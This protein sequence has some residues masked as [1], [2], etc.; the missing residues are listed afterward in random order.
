MLLGSR[1]PEQSEAY[2]IWIRLLSKIGAFLRLHSIYNDVV[3]IIVD[4]GWPFKNGFSYLS[5]PHI[6]NI[7]YSSEFPDFVYQHFSFRWTDYN[8][9]ISLLED[10]DC[11]CNLVQERFGGKKEILA[12]IAD[13]DSYKKQA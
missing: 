4:G 10:E 8:L 1:S 5:L 9:K 11:C 12:H 13:S 7:Y 3:T 6:K 2:N